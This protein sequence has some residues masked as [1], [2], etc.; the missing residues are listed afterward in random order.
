MDRF[1]PG[2]VGDWIVFCDICGKKCYSSE[3]TIL[4]N[5]TG[6]GGLAVCKQDADRIDP[7]LIPFRYPTERPVTNVRVNHTDTTISSPFID[8]ESMSYMYWL[9]A[10]QDNAVL[11]PSQE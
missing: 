2:R 8:T 6:R 4:S 3:I 10:S 5:Y 1:N 11:T 9:V 7:G